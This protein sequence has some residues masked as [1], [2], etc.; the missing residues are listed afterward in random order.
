V[1]VGLICP[2]SLLGRYG[3][4]TRYHLLLPHLLEQKKYSEF[5]LERKRNGSFLTLDNGAAEGL[6][7]GPRHLHTLARAVEADEIV[8]PDTLGDYLATIS[9]AKALVP[10][11]EPDFKYMAVVQGST[12]DEVIR[13]LY[14]FGS[15]PDMMY[16][17]CIGI[18]RHLISINERMRVNLAEFLIRESYHHR[19][20]IHFLGANRW[21]REVAALEAVVH[22]Y[23]APNW[24]SAGFRS[25]DTSTPIY[26]GLQGKSIETDAWIPR[27]E[28][29]FETNYDRYETVMQNINTYLTWA[30]DRPI[31]STKEQPQR[32]PKPW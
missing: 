25:I 1:N 27:P 3:H 8:V 20:Q 12:L 18:P 14:F 30:G 9:K 16:I 26:M 17:T 5:Y 32:R 23:L 28:H 21:V 2:T 15:A 31:L 22:D 7:Y 4:L 6:E 19:F 13:C 29:F 10:F 24:D 11:A